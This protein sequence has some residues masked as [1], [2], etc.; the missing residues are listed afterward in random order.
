MQKVEIAFE[1]TEGE[2]KRIERLGQGMGF[3][4]PQQIYLA[5]IVLGFK[6]LGVDISNT[7]PLSLIADDV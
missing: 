7:D 1:L 6:A 3:K 4:E 2:I 5:A